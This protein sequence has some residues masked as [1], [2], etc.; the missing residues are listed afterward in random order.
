MTARA[1]WRCP[2]CDWHYDETRGDRGEG[3]APGTA[4]ADFP[5]D[6]SYPTAGSGRRGSSSGRGAESREGRDG[7]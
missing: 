3:F 1:L 4:L 7:V 6:W 5:D 2:E